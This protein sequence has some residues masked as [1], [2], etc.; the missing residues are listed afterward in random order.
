MPSDEVRD[1]LA[2]WIGQAISPEGCLP[3]GTDPAAWV[4]ERFAGWW[5]EHAEGYLRDAERA[6]S[7]VRE[8]LLRLGG[9]EAFG[10]ALHELIHVEDALGDLRAALRL[11][12]ER[13]NQD[14]ARGERPGL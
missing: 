9:W 7:A 4:A 6:S 1:V 12:R 11:D 5:R 10:E 3:E 13:R 14:S 8:E 2:N